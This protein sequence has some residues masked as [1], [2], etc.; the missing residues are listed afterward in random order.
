MWRVFTERNADKALRVAPLDVREKLD[1]WRDIVEE[2]GPFGLRAVRGFRDHALK[3]Q[4]QGARSSRLNYQWRII[5]RIADTDISVFVL[6]VTPHDYRK[7][8]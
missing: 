1:L 8:S 7:K 4:W 5:Y 3:G 6:E 2:H